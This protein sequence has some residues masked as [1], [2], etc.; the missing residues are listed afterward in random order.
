MPILDRSEAEVIGARAA[1][2]CAVALLRY[3]EPGGPA[4]SSSLMVPRSVAGCA[5]SK[6][7]IACEQIVAISI[8]RSSPHREG[9]SAGGAK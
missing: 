4:F 1:L 7:K 5:T 8:E 2:A 9:S 6:L 3:E